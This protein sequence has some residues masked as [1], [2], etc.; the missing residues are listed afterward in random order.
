MKIFS[1]ILLICCVAC[2]PMRTPLVSPG[3]LA[4]LEELTRAVVDSSRI[5]PGQD[6][7]PA[8][9]SYGPNRSGITLIKPGGRDC[10]PSFWVRD[11]AM[12]LESGFITSQE[13]FDILLYTAA[14]QSDST[15]TTKTGSLVPRGSIPD[16]IRINDGLPVY[17][18]GTY[19]YV[20]QGNEIWRMPPFCDQFFF[21]HM[22]WFYVHSKNDPAIL[23]QMINNINLFN[24]LEMAFEAVPAHL[25][26]EMAFIND[27][28]PTC[29]FGFRDVITMTGEVCF[30]SLLRYRAAMEMAELCGQAGDPQKS[31]KF[32]DIAKKI[33]GHL[34]PVFADN[35]GLLRAS[36]GISRQPDVWATAFAVYIGALDGTNKARAC[37]ALANA[38]QAGTLAMEGQIRHVLT[39]DDFDSTTAW[40]KSLAGKNTY[41]NGAYWGTPTGWVCYAIAQVDK[42]AASKLAMEFI[43]QLRKTDF[44]VKGPENGGPYECVYPPSGYK[45]NPVYMTTVTCPL[46]AFK[47]ISI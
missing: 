22:A 7:P 43:D 1:G 17:F 3:D 41:Q 38:Y 5:L 6:L 37:S 14:R 39:T 18:P 34:V 42:T 8:I 12:S 4:F 15:W 23:D 16:H 2:A 29:D 27:S 11:Y 26:H 33:K 25:D 21:I 46:A 35:R 30:G 44:R 28:L 31:E 19:D 9:R 24:R 32:R 20:N 40:E 13:Q 47:K 10:Y 36:T 45:Q